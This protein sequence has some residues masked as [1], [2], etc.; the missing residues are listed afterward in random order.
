MTALS[1]LTNETKYNQEHIALA[2]NW[3]FENVYRCSSRH[4][5][6]VYSMPDQAV[7]NSIVENFGVWE[8]F[9]EYA[10]ISSNKC[11]LL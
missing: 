7:V 4:R 1:Y 11:Y 2:K 10:L 3:V 6:I 8:T 5:R 9:V